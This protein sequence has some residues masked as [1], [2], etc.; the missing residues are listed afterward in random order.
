MPATLDR[1]ALRKLSPAE[2]LD[3]ME[4]IWETLVEDDAIVVSEA[5]MLEM[6]RRADELAAHPERAVSHDDM[7]ARL[8]RIK[9]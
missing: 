6:K 1:K 8:A 7:M 3:L 9:R 5:T 4:R 2:R